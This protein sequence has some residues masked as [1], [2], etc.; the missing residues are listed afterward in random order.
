[1]STLSPRILIDASGHYDLSAVAA[2]TIGKLPQKLGDTTTHRLIAILQLEGGQV[3]HTDTDYPKAAA[4]WLA[5][6]AQEDVLY[7][8]PRTVPPPIPPP[9]LAPVAPPSP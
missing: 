7:S 4:A 2:M 6:K 3:L 9:D 8:A 5:V 1:M